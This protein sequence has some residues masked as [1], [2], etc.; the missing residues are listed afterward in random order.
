MLCKCACFRVSAHC[1]GGKEAAEALLLTR[2]VS[3]L[4]ECVLPSV[5]WLR[6]LMLVLYRALS[7]SS[8][9]SNSPHS[10]VQSSLL[11]LHQQN[12]NNGNDCHNV[13]RSFY[14]HTVSYFN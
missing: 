5:S 6:S 4:Q 7:A 10:A 1:V 13:W 9:S 8:P 12:A 14:V 3:G 2:V 11:C